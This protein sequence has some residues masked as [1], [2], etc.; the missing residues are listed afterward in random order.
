MGVARHGEHVDLFAHLLQA[1]LVAH[2]ET[3]LFVDN[4]QAEIL[5]LDVFRKNA[6]G[7]DEDIDFA[8]LELFK[9]DLLLLGRA[10]ARDHFDGDGKL[11]RSVS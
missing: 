10:E 9:D 11:C 4:K 5:E 8:G 2:A 3:L 1:L 7:A 6:V